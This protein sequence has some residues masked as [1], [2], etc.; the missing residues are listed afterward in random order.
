MRNLTILTLV[1]VLLGCAVKKQSK[2]KSEDSINTSSTSQWKQHPG[3][4]KFLDTTMY[5][6]ADG[7]LVMTVHVKKGLDTLYVED[8]ITGDI[9]MVVS[10]PKE[11]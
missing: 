4:A 11:K 6:N 5:E 9:I 10:D 8:P 1:I 2:V 3:N 7:E